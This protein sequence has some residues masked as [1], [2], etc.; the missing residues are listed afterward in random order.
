MLIGQNNYKVI[1]LDT[2]AIREI[3]TNTCNSGKGFFSKFLSDDS[4]MYVPCISLYNVLELKPYEDIY[5]KF[6][7]FF[8]S[9]PC[10]VFYPAKSIIREEYNAYIN[11][12]PLSICNKIA[13]AFSPLGPNNSYNCR[14]FFEKIFE[15]EDLV[16][17]IDYNI[18]ELP[19]VASEWENQR[20]N[21]KRMLHKLNFPVNMINEKYYKAQE[22]ATITK[23]LSN[24]GINSFD[25]DTISSFPAARI[26]S[27]S[28]FSR[29]HLTKK[30]IFPNDVMDVTIS[31]IVPYI[32]AVITEK[33]QANV[34]EKAKNFIPQL[35]KLGIY[36]LKD[37]RLNC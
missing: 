16:S 24:W 2:N 28:Q 25:S 11:N 37:I 32:D 21:A 5:E 14:S 12:T 26:M 4:S 30:R 33:F 19:S 27:Y 22:S 6:L 35:K 36:T 17:T 10:F 1:L 3:I 29:I 9:I 23:D 34:Y 15:R 18:A 20:I 31:S 7:D 8:S 13:N